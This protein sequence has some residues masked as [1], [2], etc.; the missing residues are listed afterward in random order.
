MNTIYFAS[1]AQYKT[2]TN[3]STLEEQHQS[4]EYVMPLSMNLKFWIQYDTKSN[5][6]CSKP[7]WPG[8]SYKATKTNIVHQGL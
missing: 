6:W 5:I 4:V 7:I 3:F 1:V 2:G 8:L